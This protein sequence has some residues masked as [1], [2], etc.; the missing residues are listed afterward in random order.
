MNR[1]EMSLGEKVIRD[2]ETLLNRLK[3]MNDGLAGAVP[4]GDLRLA[5]VGLPANVLHSYLLQF[6][7]AEYTITHKAWWNEAYRK[8]EPTASDMQAIKNL[9]SMMK[10]AT[11]VFFLSRI[12]WTFRKLITFLFPGACERGGAAFKT[13]YDYLLNNI[14]LEKYIALYDLC[15]HIRNSVHSNG[16][17]ISRTGVDQTVTWKGVT[18][19]FSHMGTIDFVT[20]D[21]VFGLYNDLIDSIEEI[22]GSAKVREPAFIEDRVH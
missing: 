11:I 19:K 16:I 18:Y 6:A 12:E 9:E 17:F 22:L 13:I 15:R 3:L 14:G 5:A 8:T 21:F 7:M 1:A 20:H 4:K 2:I 10:H